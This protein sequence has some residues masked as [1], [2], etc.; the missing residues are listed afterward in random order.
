M[1]QPPRRSRALFVPVLAAVALGTM[2]QS[3]PTVGSA[4][5]LYLA[6]GTW[7]GTNAGAIVTD[8]QTHVHI[9]CT[10]GDISGLVPLS[11]DGSFSVAGRYLL[12]AYPITV[13]PYL[14]AQFSGRVHQYLGISTLTLTVV[15]DD[16]VAKTAQTLG[17]VDVSLGKEPAMGPCP[18]CRVPR[19]WMPAEPAP[20]R[21]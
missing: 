3:N 13:G 16:T 6:K 7:G 4:G 21:R 2:C 5:G 12:R 11:S 14:P 10:F 17:P 1:P 20:G 15:V 9:G 8:S 18:I 19:R